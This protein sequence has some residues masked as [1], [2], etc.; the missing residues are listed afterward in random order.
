MTAARIER[1]PTLV[2][3]G[4]EPGEALRLVGRLLGA[5]PP[6]ETWAVLA[7]TGGALPAAP[8]VVIAAAQG[9]PCCTG[10]VALR[11]ALTR[12]L[13]SARPHRLFVELAHDA[14]LPQALAS[15]RGPWLATALDVQG[16]VEAPGGTPEA[17]A[18][19]VKAR[20]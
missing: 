6:G 5:R 9:C 7:T 13:R 11:V 2:V 18:A 19:A 10:Q 12:L 15:L 1:V 8:G 20:S 14:H 16:V 3:T 17:A 4:R